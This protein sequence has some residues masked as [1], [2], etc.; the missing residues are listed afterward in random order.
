MEMRQT[1]VQT[2]KLAVT[3]WEELTR[4]SKTAKLGIK[5]KRSAE[6]KKPKLASHATPCLVQASQEN[7]MGAGSVPSVTQRDPTEEGR[8]FGKSASE[9]EEHASSPPI[10][11]ACKRFKRISAG[12]EKVKEIGE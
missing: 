10:Q 1:D 5:K 8:G 4:K 7:R 9:G 3:L 11:K 2:D 12:A 6:S